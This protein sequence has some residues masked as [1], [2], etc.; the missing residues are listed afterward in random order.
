M[1]AAG[2]QLFLSHLLVDGQYDFGL[3]SCED[4]SVWRCWFT[5][6]LCSLVLAPGR[7]PVWTELVAAGRISQA[8]VKVRCPEST[9]HFPGHFLC[10]ESMVHS[11]DTSSF[12]GDGDL[13]VALQLLDNSILELLSPWQWRLELLESS[14]QLLCHIVCAAF[15]S[16]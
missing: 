8:G 3:S 11:P 9:I 16:Q 12:T 1:Y 15:F 14:A 13:K 5:Q 6:G 2:Q 4:R 7:F 10:P